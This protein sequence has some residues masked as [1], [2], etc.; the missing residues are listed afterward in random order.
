MYLK[1]SFRR[2]PYINDIAAYYRSV[3]SYRNE[4]DRVC[5]KTFLNIGFWADATREQKD[6][7]VNHLNERYK[8]ELALFEEPD[9]QVVEWVNRFWN[10]M[11]R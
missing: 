3:G 11:I 6:K 7:V 4:F 1:A 9:E 5:H 2:N 10:G 8:N